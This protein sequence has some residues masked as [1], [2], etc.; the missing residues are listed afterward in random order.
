M[1]K[2]GAGCRVPG[3][4]SRPFWLPGV[5]DFRDPGSGTALNE[6]ALPLVLSQEMEQRHATPLSVLTLV[7]T[8]GLGR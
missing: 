3:S 2:S 8:V 6:T 1:P 5:P 4:R 7:P